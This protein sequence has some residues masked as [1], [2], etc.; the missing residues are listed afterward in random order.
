MNQWCQLGFGEAAIL[1]R[2][3][4]IVRIA[5][6]TGGVGPLGKV[7]GTFSSRDN[8]SSLQDEDRKATCDFVVPLGVPKV[9]AQIASHTMK[10]QSKE[11][12]K[13]WFPAN[14]VFRCQSSIRLRVAL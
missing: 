7:A 13:G 10:W 5:L 11:A 2:E 1:S 14:L 9:V 3:S 8:A 12:R 4:I 6:N